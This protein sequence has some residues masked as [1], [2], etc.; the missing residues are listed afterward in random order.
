MD[1]GPIG[2]SVT[3]I[4]SG[5][6][7]GAGAINHIVNGSSLTNILIVVGSAIDLTGVTFQNW[8]S[9]DTL[10]LTGTGGADTLIGSDQVQTL[11]G[12][13]GND[14]L[15]GGASAD[16]LTGGTGRDI[17]SGGLGADYFDFNSTKESKKGAQRDTITDFNHSELDQIDLAGIDAKKHAHGNQKFKF[18]GKHDFHGKEGELHYV[19]HGTS[20]WVEGDVNGD[21]RA[22]FQIKV[23]GVSSLSSGDFQL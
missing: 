19:K 1:L 21:G 3:V 14:T 17:Q 16:V 11:Q 15:T 8:G 10:R 20:V 18:I 2:G 13:A 23:D 7:I 12:L 4:L 9:D 6:Q 22:D 5:A